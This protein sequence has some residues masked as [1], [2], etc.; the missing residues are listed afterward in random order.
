MSDYVFKYRVLKG[1][2]I[3]YT[4]FHTQSRMKSS[5]I[6]D[7]LECFDHI[8]HLKIYNKLYL[9]IKEKHKAIERDLKQSKHC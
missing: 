3:V 4:L 1:D 7:I 6:G 9:E 2:R 5:F 8:T